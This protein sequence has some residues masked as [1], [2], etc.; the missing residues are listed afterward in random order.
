MTI[1]R[2][3]VTEISKMFNELCLG[4]KYCIEIIGCCTEG[5]CMSYEMCS[6]VHTKY[7]KMFVL[8]FFQSIKSMDMEIFIW[9]Q[10]MCPTKLYFKRLEKLQSCCVVMSVFFLCSKVQYWVFPGHNVG[11][12]NNF[13]S[14]KNVS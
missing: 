1:L 2:I 6:N 12:Q 11:I 5:N 4:C 14:S 3:S 9:L 10:L 7:Y 13:S 8:I